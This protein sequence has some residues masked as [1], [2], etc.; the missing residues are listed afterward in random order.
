MSGAVA[1]I[2]DSAASLPPALARTWGIGV[3][4]L[5]VVIDGEAHDE[6]ER[7]GADQV[8]EALIA[9]REASTS[10]PSVAAFE[11]AFARAAREGATHVVAVLISSKM[12][13]TVNGARSAAAAADV[14]VTVVDSRTLAM[15]TGFAAI[16]AAALAREGAGPAEVAAE[17]E[18]V[19]RSSQ[20]VFTVDTL[21]F[22][23]RGGRVSPAV[24]AVGR[25]LSVRPVLELV[26]GEVAMVERVRSTHRAR[27]AV[28]ARAEAAMAPMARPA[29]AVM[30][31][32]D[33]SYGDQAAHDLEERHP[34]LGLLVRTPVSAVL[35]VHTGPG[36]FA[37]V[38]ADLPAR[39]R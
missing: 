36:T 38:A 23:R 1:V 24:A 30:M 15:A 9:G 35:A 16:A 18:R 17:A 7:M 12:S 20:C 14:P 2:T 31:L 6:G 39:V 32:G 19:A 4:P 22:L 33:A 34:D 27:A 28:L 8:I 11:R 21:D 13:G 25:V 29:S 3:V 10:Q 26:D 5:Q 37:A